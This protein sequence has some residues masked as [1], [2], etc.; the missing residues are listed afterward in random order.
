MAAKFG[1]SGLR[2]LVGELDDGTA[3]AYTTA[4]LRHLRASGSIADGDPV[5]VGQDLRPSSAEIAAHCMAA[6]EDEKLEPVDCGTL[7]T[8]ALAVHAMAR[9]A[10]SIMITGSH[11]PADRNG[12]KFY[13]PDGEIDKGDEAAMTAS[14]ET[15]DKAALR[16]TAHHKP[17]E[18]EAGARAGFV[19]RY[20][21]FLA[22]GCLAGRRIGI[23][24]H[25]SVIRSVLADILAPTGAEIVPVGHSETFIPVDT[26]A[27]SDQTRARIRV[28]VERY[29]LDALVSADGDGDRPLVADEKGAVIRGDVLGL[30]VSR[31]LEADAVI[32]PVTSNSG[33]E[34]RVDARTRRTKVGSPYVIA[35]MAAAAGDGARRI[36]GFEANGGVLTGSP[37]TFG[38]AEL[39]AL[40]TRDS[41]LPILA[42]LAVSLGSR[43]ALSALV[44]GLALPVAASGRIENFPTGKG[45]ALVASLSG[46]ET[47]RADFLAPIGEVAS[48][49]MTDG[50]R[51]TLADGRILHLRPS[52][53]APEMRVY[54]EAA[55][56]ADAEALISA[57]S[58]RILTA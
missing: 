2:G 35:E 55:T 41:V 31:L 21:G 44:E 57:A 52:G 5:F 19:A 11:I 34:T 37:F 7:P 20:R 29:G 40:P 16:W 30:V 4:F 42:M 14:V 8:P 58:E 32:T 46:D 24:E 45:K 22:E 18:E 56:Q 54:A 33:I 12:V 50:L 49:D 17:A 13:R 36:V 6:I 39:S 10:A 26:E 47:A 51:M 9:K 27:V 3:A 15:V 38:K 23:Y 43:L 28:W 25:S 1:T 53:N 48:F